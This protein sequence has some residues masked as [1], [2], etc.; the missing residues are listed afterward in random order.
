MWVSKQLSLGALIPVGRQ[1]SK[2]GQS[3]SNST[4]YYYV[5]SGDIELLTLV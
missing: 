2:I 5:R 1:V 3:S 4:T